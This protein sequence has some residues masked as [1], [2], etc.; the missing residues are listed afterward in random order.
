MGFF[1]GNDPRSSVEVL[2]SIPR[3]R[4]RFGRPVFISVSRKSF[5]RA[6]TGRALD[7][8]GAA[9]LT[10]ELYAARA[11]TDYLRTHDVGALRDGLRIEAT[12][13]EQ[14]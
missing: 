3:L 1:L 14:T 9:T 8:V 12:L 11:G 6:I 4:A 10:A 13:D 5:L 2:Q 7:A